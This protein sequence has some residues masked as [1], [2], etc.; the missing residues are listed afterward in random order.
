MVSKKKNKSLLLSSTRPFSS[1][2]PSSLSS[3]KTQSIVR[4]HHVL[5]KKLHKATVQKDEVA[6]TDILGKIEAA[7]GLK[8]YQEASIQGQSIH[9]G[10]DS[11][12][13]LMKWVS[14]ATI[15]PSS[16][17][18]ESE[19]S[20]MLEVGALRIDN[21]CSRSGLFN[22][23]RIDLHSQH[24]QI[25]EE[26]FMQ[27]TIPALRNEGFDI[28]SL[29]LVVNFV[30]DAVERGEMLKRV[31]SFLRHK[32]SADGID[33]L[34]FPSLFLVLPAPC[35]TNSRYLNEERL[36]EMMKTL[37]YMRAKRRMSVKLVYYLW[38]YDG[39]AKGAMR[40]FKKEEVR[41]GGSRNNFAIVLQ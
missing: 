5:R 37:G 6:V 26:D 19:R 3:R 36:E 24:P 41:M 18:K 32:S 29:S 9:R 39:Q 20:R 40:V 13:M 10:G 28:V 16:P 11:S 21:A 4:A 33:G 25:K 31:G 8:T 34:L 38:K 14:E 22:V 23:E 27:R 2:R 35:V 17:L 30:S 1:K 7:G 12:K 15:H